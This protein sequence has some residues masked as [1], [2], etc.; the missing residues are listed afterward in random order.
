MAAISASAGYFLIFSG[1]HQAKVGIGMGVRAQ[2]RARAVGRFGE[3]R[4]FDGAGSQD[5]TVNLGRGHRGTRKPRFAV[6]SHGHWIGCTN[7]GGWIQDSREV[8]AGAPSYPL[9]GE[10]RGKTEK[11][12]PDDGGG[13]R[14]VNL[15]G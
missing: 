7:E 10:A 3:G 12:P 9:I 15:R 14:S 8:G 13:F 1:Q 4:A 5:F 6:P 2:V 11:P